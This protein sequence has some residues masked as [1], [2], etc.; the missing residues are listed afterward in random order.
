MTDTWLT[1]AKKICRRDDMVSKH[2]PL[3]ISFN[4]TYGFEVSTT[5]PTRYTSLGRKTGWKNSWETAGLTQQHCKLWSWSAKRKEF[6]LRRYSNFLCTLDLIRA[7]SI[8]KVI[9]TQLLVRA[10]IVS[11][12]SNITTINN[13]INNASFIDE[14][15]EELVE[16]GGGWGSCGWCTCIYYRTEW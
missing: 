14:W 5:S 10:S 12:N 7:Y 8:C 2:W 6:K 1:A 11:V 13:I 16:G 4:Q 15:G 9:E 3:I